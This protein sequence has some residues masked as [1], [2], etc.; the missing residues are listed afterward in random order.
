M[1]FG[2]QKGNGET[3]AGIARFGSVDWLFREYKSSKA[4]LA[5][6][7]PRTRPDY[8]RIMQLVVDHRTNKGDRIGDRP[9]KAITPV[10]AD[11]LYER[12][13]HG[14]KGLRLRQGEKV[15]ALCRRAWRVGGHARAGLCLRVGRHQRWAARGR[16]GS[17]ALF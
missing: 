8:E 5:R 17:G 13:I 14:P 7:S 9:I 6:V 10:A 4:Y 11:K 2:R 3:L 1:A 12:L 15:I 16:R